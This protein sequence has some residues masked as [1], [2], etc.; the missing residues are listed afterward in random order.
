MERDRSGRRVP[1]LT[2]VIFPPTTVDL[3]LELPAEQSSVDA[4]SPQDAPPGADTGS[5]TDTMPFTKDT[6]PSISALLASVHHLA[7]APEEDT[8]LARVLADLR[9][10]LDAG[11]EARMREVLGAAMAR[12]ADAAIRETSDQLTEAMREAI[13]R[14]VAQELARHRE[15]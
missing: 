8:P 1:T 5:A 6:I 4:Q 9:R 7:A 10:Q 11:L 13:E 14:A 3:L 15:V 12:A 2:E